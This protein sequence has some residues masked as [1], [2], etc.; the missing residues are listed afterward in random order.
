MREKGRHIFCEKA[1]AANSR[2]YR[3]L[4]EWVKNKAEL[5]V[6]LALQYKAAIVLDV[7][8]DSSMR[9]LK[10]SGGHPA[11]REALLDFS[12]LRRLIKELAEWHGVPYIEARLYSTACSEC[13]AKMHELH[14]GRVRRAGCNLHRR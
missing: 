4:R 8:D 11:G 10:E 7:P 3:L 13:G 9:E 5:T 2:L 12:R 6:W 14:G 1:R